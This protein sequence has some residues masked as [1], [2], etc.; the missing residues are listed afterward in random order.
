MNIIFNNLK[1]KEKVF[2][3]NFISC[4][5]NGTLLNIPSYKK[6]F[7]EEAKNGNVKVS[8]IFCDFVE[9]MNINTTFMSSDLTRRVLNV[10]F[11][12]LDSGNISVIYNDKR[13]LGFNISTK[14]IESTT[15]LN[16]LDCLSSLNGLS[17]DSPIEA[18]HLVKNKILEY[19]LTNDIDVFI[20]DK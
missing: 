17:A 9:N 14:Q 19:G 2:D 5:N 3:E 4:I 15:A 6:L 7:N 12:R 13:C 16:G 1:I 20:C 8:D 18:Y 10:L 11:L